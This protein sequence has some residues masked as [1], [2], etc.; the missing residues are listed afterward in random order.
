MGATLALG[1]LQ[2]ERCLMNKARFL[3]ER[4]AAWERFETLLHEATASRSARLKPAEA[5]EFSELFRALCYDLATVRAR[6]WGSGLERYLN[7]LVVRGHG[8]YYG[9]KPHRGGEILSFFTERF[10]R[11]LRANARYFWTST[12]LFMGPFAISWMVVQAHPELATRVLPARILAQFDEMYSAR[13]EEERA[14]RPPMEATAAGF[15]VRNNTSI[16]FR[17]FAMGVFFGAGT[18]YVLLFNGIYLGTVTGYV[19][20]QGHGERFTSFVVSHGAFE[21]TAIAISGAAGLVLGH[22]VLAPGALTRARALRE[23][24]LVAVQLALGAGG[25]LAVAALI[26]GFWSPSAVPAQAKYVVGG[27]LWVAVTAYLSLAGRRVE[28]S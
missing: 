24:G 21:L 28:S 6:D 16:A 26:E 20:A 15:Y 23:R 25:M 9:S 13:A 7:D 8:A 12:A 11:L 4:R 3:V 27:V 1:Q 19:I 14:Q 2:S 18:I 5:S 22:A 17:C 10:P